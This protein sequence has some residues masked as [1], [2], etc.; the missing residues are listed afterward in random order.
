MAGGELIKPCWISP[1]SR[2]RPGLERQLG[3]NRFCST[4]RL[5]HL[6]RLPSSSQRM[7]IGNV[8][9]RI[10]SVCLSQ[11]LAKPLFGADHE[12]VTK[13]C[14]R[15]GRKG[16]KPAQKPAFTPT[17]T[18]ARKRCFGRSR[19]RLQKTFLPM[20]NLTPSSKGANSNVERLV[21]PDGDDRVLEVFSVRLVPREFDTNS[22]RMPKP[23]A[24]SGSDRLS[25][26][27]RNGW[28]IER[29]VC[30]LSRPRLAA[31]QTTRATA[32]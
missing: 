14:R 11:G 26:K 32:R 7:E 1:T 12:V 28:P 13:T 21:H 4:H 8:P 16:K 18:Q 27:H 24:A 20:R 9:A 10:G 3:E 19:F 31:D 5:G 15:K 22:L 6:R 23:A 17:K 29:P 2:R 25:Q 30:A